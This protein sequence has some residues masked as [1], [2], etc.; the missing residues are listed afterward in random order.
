MSAAVLAS[1]QSNIRVAGDGGGDTAAPVGN[2]PQ[3][4]ALLELLGAKCAVRG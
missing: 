4:H 1:R 3:L 2:Y